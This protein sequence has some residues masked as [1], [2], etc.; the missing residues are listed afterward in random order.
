MKMK[1]TSILALSLSLVSP[2]FAAVLITPTG[3]T[4]ITDSSDLF[5][6]GDGGLINNSLIGTPAT[7]AN[8]TTTTHVNVTSG[9][10]GWVTADPAPAGGDYF[11][12]GENNPNPVL[13]FALDQTYTL[14][15]FVFW[16]YFNGG[17]GNEAK[18]FT[19]EFSTT[20]TSGTFSGTTPLTQ[21]TAVGTG[22]PATLNFAAVNANAVR[23]TITD[24]QGGID[25]VGLGEV[26][27]IGSAVPEP[28]STA[29]LGLGGLAL[30]L[31]RR[32]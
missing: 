18:A 30:I 14:T 16:G 10:V 17:T 3:V 19:L 21:P 22:N 32:K 27:F 15:D 29:L 1:N 11:G 20:G 28:S 13:T 5:K 23:I 31:R 4:S 24:N 7:L 12:P 6:V 2:G 26:K 9:S 8:Y 25:R